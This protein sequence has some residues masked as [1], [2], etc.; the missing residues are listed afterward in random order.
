MRR[1]RLNLILK[2]LPS[3]PLDLA[4]QDRIGLDLTP[5]YLLG[6]KLYGASS[7]GV[8]MNHT[9]SPR[10]DCTQEVISL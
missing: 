3:H 10:G 1:C 5:G 6:L 7:A 9:N 8:T 2:M 4:L